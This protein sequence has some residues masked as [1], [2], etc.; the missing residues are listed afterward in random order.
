M[1][2][3]TQIHTDNVYALAVKSAYDYKDVLSLSAQITYTV[4][5]TV[6][7]TE[8]YLFAVKPD[9]EMHPSLN[10]FIPPL[11][12]NINPGYD[13]ISRKEV[14]EIFKNDRN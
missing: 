6:T 12:F 11:L 10:V 9:N 5:G 2:A 13:Y 1:L 7:I 14:K 4:T 3:F 8:E